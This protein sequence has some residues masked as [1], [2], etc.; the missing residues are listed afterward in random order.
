MTED[1]VLSS[2]LA[3]S[4]DDKLEAFDKS[5]TTAILLQAGVSRARTRQLENEL[6]IAYG[7]D[8]LTSTEAV[9]NTYLFTTRVFSFNMDDLMM[10]PKKHPIVMAFI[11]KYNEVKDSQDN[12]TMVFKCNGTRMVASTIQ[13]NESQTYLSIAGLD[14][15]MFVCHFTDYFKREQPIEV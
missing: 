3:S 9:G 4:K 13:P 10:K 8:W 14:C 2:F 15:P 5:T 1:D 11:D 6:G 12:V 7:S